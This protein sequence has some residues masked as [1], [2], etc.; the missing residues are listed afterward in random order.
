MA[1]RGH[2]TASGSETPRVMSRFK[3]RLMKD[4]AN[5]R[6]KQSDTM[7]EGEL[8]FSRQGSC[9][10]LSDDERDVYNTSKQEGI[11]SRLWKNQIGC[12]EQDNCDAQSELGSSYENNP[13]I[14]GFF[15]RAITHLEVQMATKGD[16]EGAVQVALSV[17]KSLQ[18]RVDRETSKLNEKLQQ[19]VRDCILEQE[20]IEK[21]LEGQP[22]KLFT[23]LKKQINK[24]Q[25]QCT[26][27]A[28]QQQELKDKMENAMFTLREEYSQMIPKC[29]NR[30]NS[31]SQTL[32]K[33]AQ[34]FRQL[35]VQ[36]QKQNDLER[37]EFKKQAHSTLDEFIKKTS[38]LQAENLK[39]IS[40]L[41]N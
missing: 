15:Q 13:R 34:E 2:K 41:E 18:D 32:H 27:T 10:S 1:Q 40:D 8:Q 6:L 23:E 17:E 39:K 7:K 3:H 11:L 24:I 33:D 12:K 26:A 19:T 30:I 38:L 37:I 22:I 25:S 35:I 16:I 36:L 5:E 28:S 31:L 29:E 21:K 4:V 20:K 9:D 14:Q